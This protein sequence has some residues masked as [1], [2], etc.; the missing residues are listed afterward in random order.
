MTLNLPSWSLFSLGPVRPY[1]SWPLFCLLLC[2]VC[3]R[4]PL[5]VLL[6]TFQL[7]FF[8]LVALVEI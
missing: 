5:M 6:L 7:Y 3:S 2:S 1:I 8:A 4:I